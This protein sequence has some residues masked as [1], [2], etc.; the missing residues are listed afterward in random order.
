MNRTGIP[1]TALYRRLKK[2]TELNLIVAERRKGK[3]YYR[4]AKRE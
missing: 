2:L 4:L 3:Y 1:K